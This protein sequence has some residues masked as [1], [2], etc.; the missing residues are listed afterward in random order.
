M[1]QLMLD[2]VAL[3][4]RAARL[5]GA[6]AAERVAAFAARLA[7]VADHGTSAEDRAEAEARRLLTAL[8]A[9]ADQAGPRVSA[10]LS[11]LLAEVFDQE[12]AKAE[13]ADIER[14]G[15]VRLADMMTDAI[16]AW[17]QDQVADIEAGLGGLYQ[18][19]N[20]ELLGE[21]AAVRDA[22]A[23]LL[24]LELTLPATGL[25]L[26]PDLHFL[27]SFDERADQ[28]ELLAGAV[29]RRLPGE[30][31]RRIARQHLS[32]LVPELTDRQLGRA[33]SDLQYRLAE[34]TRRLLT[35]IRQSHRD[36]T[37][38]LTAALER[39]A[40]IRTQS[41]AEGARQLAELGAREPSLR[42]VLRLLT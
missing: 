34:S 20:R 27:Y 22:A 26:E 25:R 24:G 28:A 30:A 7:I 33:R 18:Q 9:A 19:V 4:E 1:A 42:Q 35:D 10:D 17:R 5:P 12:L 2:E 23:D 8:N 3:A 29:R 37:D 40:Q 39:S 31:G 6:R 32:G 15:R 38:R 41:A 13:S 16:E 11:T 21:L 14:R 36:S